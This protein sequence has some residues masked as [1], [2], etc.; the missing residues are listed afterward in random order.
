[1]EDP[2]APILKALSEIKKLKDNRGTIMCPECGST[3]HYTRAQN[4]HVWG[5]CTKEGCLRWMM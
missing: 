1:M 5:K 2:L 4:G 3:L